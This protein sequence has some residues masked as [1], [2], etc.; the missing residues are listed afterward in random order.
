MPLAPQPDEPTTAAS[1]PPASGYPVV[2]T[3]QDTCYGNGPEMACPAEGAI[4]YG[5]DAQYTG[6]AP[7]YTDNGDGTVTDDVTGIMW[8]QSP[9]TD[10]DG[11]IDADDKFIQADAVGYCEALTLAGYDDW[12]LPDIKTL[13]ALIDFRGTDPMGDDTSN[14]IPFIDTDVF[15]FAYGDRDAGERVIDAQFASS[16]LYVA[17]TMNGA[18]T[19]FGVNLADGRIKGYGLLGRGG[20]EKTFYVLCARDLAD[21]GVNDFVDNGDGTVTDR[22]TGLMWT[23]DDNGAGVNWGDALAYVDAKNAESYRGYSDWRLPNAK[24]L[25]SIVDYTRAPDVTNSA[26]IDPVF[27]V[28]TITNLAGELD[29]PFYWTGTTH[30][31]V[32]G[33]GVAAVYV[34]FG[35][36]LGSMD[37]G[38]T[39][40]DVHGAGCQRSDPKDGDPAAYPSAGNGPQ[41]DVQ[42]VFNH[43]RLVRDAAVD[44]A[45]PQ[46]SIAKTVEVDVSVQPGDAVTYTVTVANSGD[47]DATGVT[48]TDTLPSALV[49]DDLSWSGTVPAREQVSFVIPTTIRDDS[50]YLGQTISNTV[51]YSHSSGSGSDRASFTVPSSSAG[52]FDLYLPLML[53][54]AGGTGE[55][56]TCLIDDAGDTVFAPEHLWRATSP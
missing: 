19:M 36:G 2:D 33:S 32:D 3:G 42:R 25:Q 51:S 23:Q 54:D 17:T 22:A 4:F 37:G 27:N 56:T 44:P 24:E 47:A 35:R 48:V 28:S 8:Q 11:D 30:R 5:Q 20:D 13:Y 39:V 12:Q 50:L 7:S 53:Q 21:Y 14:L 43:V 52:P 31:R 18:E 9:D 15:D 45:G 1:N 16:T 46:L 55:A 40:I 10:G 6:N 41:G 49:G 38:K 26:A 29:Y 34:A